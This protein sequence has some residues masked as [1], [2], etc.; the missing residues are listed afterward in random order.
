MIITES[1]NFV[2]NP[3]FYNARESGAKKLFE[4]DI[5]LPTI[6]GGK[7]FLRGGPLKLPLF[8]QSLIVQGLCQAHRLVEVYTMFWKEK[9]TERASCS[10]SSN[11][12]EPKPR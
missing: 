8:K 1:V 2:N 9:E 12:L 7:G 11:P 6:C 3:S 5:V 4:K 10:V